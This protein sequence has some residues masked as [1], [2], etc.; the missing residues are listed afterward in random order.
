ME[1]D[2]VNHVESARREVFEMV[3]IHASVFFVFLSVI[4]CK[5]VFERDTGSRVIFLKA[6][7]LDPGS[8]P[9]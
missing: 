5:R 2:E 9:G 4:P 1:H 3:G 7:T 8:S 6:L